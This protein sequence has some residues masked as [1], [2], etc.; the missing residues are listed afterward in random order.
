M[1]PLY[2]QIEGYEDII[3]AA[4]PN[5]GGLGAFNAAFG[6][7]VE[8]FLGTGEP[9]DITNEIEDSVPSKQF[10]ISLLSLIHI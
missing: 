10:N 7:N 8:K 6:N 5:R 3:N 4:E 2:N 1:S 9:D